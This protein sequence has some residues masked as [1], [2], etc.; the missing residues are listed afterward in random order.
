MRLLLAEDDPK[1][2]KSLMH[3]FETNKFAVDGV[4][5]GVD[6]DS[7]QLLTANNQSHKVELLANAPNGD[8]D[9][10]YI[11]YVGMITAVG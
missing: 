10:L 9:S 7:V 4:V 11:N 6:R 2:L 1:L 8:D 5:S 3:I